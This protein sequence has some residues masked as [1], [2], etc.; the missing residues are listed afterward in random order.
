MVL[1]AESAP[2][3]GRGPREIDVLLRAFPTGKLSEIVGPSSSGG[4]SLLLALIARATISGDQVAVVDAAD[5]FDPSRADAAGVVLSRLLWVKC[6]GRLALAW[7]VADLLVRCPGF[8]LIAL[9]VG[10]LANGESS[11]RAVFRRLQ[12]ATEKSAAALVLRA[13]RPLAGNAAAMVVSVRRL[14]SGWIGVPRPTRF[15]GL[16]SEVRVLRDRAR[17]HARP[18]EGDLIEAGWR[19]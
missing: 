5:A 2:P 15:T 17:S 19:L 18:R 14:E 8:A 16:T 1:H 3:P 11:A 12:L 6:R 10:D 13:P 4:S 7:T 9:D